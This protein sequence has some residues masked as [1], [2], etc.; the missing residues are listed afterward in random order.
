MWAGQINEQW[1]DEVITR[2]ASECKGR[3]FSIMCDEVSD[4]SNSELLS[5]VVRY[6][7]DSG[8]VKE[9][10][11]ALVKVVSTAGADLCDVIVRC[12]NCLQFD[13]N[14]LIAQ[15]YDG[16]SNMSGRYNGVQA[17]LKSLY[18]REPLFV[19]CWAHVL[20]LVIQDVVKS[21]HLCSRTFELLQKIYVVVE[22][23]PKC[24]SEYMSCVVDHAP[25]RWLASS[26]VA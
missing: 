1:V 12:L 2:I 8:K 17:R 22:G 10:L 25:R 16:A 19:H 13:L 4:R 26:A 24:H 5:L 14:L 21:V 23:S 15:C 7:L 6:T 3:F 18:P 20:N 11:I 9:A